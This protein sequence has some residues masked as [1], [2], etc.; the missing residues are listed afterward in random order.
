MNTVV[1]LVFTLLVSTITLAQ[2]TISLT[3][4]IP[5]VR[6]DNGTVMIAIHNEETF[7]KNPLHSAAVEIVD[8]KANHTF[9]DITP[10]EYAVMVMH[11]ENDNKQMDYESNGMPKEDYAMSGE[12]AMYGP[13]SYEQTKIMLDEDQ[14]MTLRF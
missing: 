2:E 6:N 1:T 5:N 8:G 13:P 3:V 11:D 4:E 9:T 7:M 14:T 12:P 10:G